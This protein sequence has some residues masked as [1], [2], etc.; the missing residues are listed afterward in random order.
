[1]ACKASDTD[2]F[3]AWHSISHV[4]SRPLRGRPPLLCSGLASGDM[5]AMICFLLPFNFRRTLL[6]KSST[7][8]IQEWSFPYK[9]PKLLHQKENAMEHRCLTRQGEGAQTLNNRK[10][11]IINQGSFLVLAYRKMIFQSLY[12]A[13]RAIVAKA[14]VVLLE[15]SFHG[16]H[17]HETMRPMLLL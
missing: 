17:A 3:R 12:R 6:L 8:S 5:A 13:G 4:T 15:V 1:M 10:F 16:L 7:S 14:V 2:F 11:P 9:S